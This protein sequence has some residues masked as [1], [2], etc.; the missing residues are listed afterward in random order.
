MESMRITRLALS[1]N[2][3]GML[4]SSR[5]VK[6]LLLSFLCET[7][8]RSWHVRFF[9]DYVFFFYRHPASEKSSSLFCQFCLLSSVEYSLYTYSDVTVLAV[10]CIATSSHA[11]RWSILSSVDWTYFTSPDLDPNRSLFV[12]LS[13]FSSTMILHLPKSPLYVF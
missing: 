7:Y 1:E 3:R 10:F 5:S 11:T 4:P 9:L 8:A 13:F 6:N 12:F 2:L